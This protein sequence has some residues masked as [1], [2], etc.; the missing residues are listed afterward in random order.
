MLS[1][2][3]FGFGFDVA[4]HTFSVSFIQKRDE[5]PTISDDMRPVHLNW[6][7]LVWAT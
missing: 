4:F 6:L 5:L 2:A 1:D 7:W 3:C